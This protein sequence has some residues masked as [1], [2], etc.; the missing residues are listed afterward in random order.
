MDRLYA[1]VC[2]SVKWSTT[3]S[4][5]LAGTELIHMRMAMG[6]DFCHDVWYHLMTGRILRHSATLQQVGVTPVPYPVVLSGRVFLPSKMLWSHLLRGRASA[7]IPGVLHCLLVPEPCSPL[8]TPS[9]RGNP[10]PHC[11]LT[12]HQLD[13]HAGL[14][15][16]MG[17][18]CAVSWSC[19]VGQDSPGSLAAHSSRQ[20]LIWKVM[21]GSPSIGFGRR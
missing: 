3:Q 4:S 18:L 15:V 6:C 1:S 8:E 11:H 21:R 14:I 7:C 12:L 16:S 10:G 17:H 5:C 20:G 9:M 2:S 19:A 13:C